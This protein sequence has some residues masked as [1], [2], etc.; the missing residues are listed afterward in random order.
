MQ[1]LNEKRAII[2]SKKKEINQKKVTCYYGRPI[3]VRGPVFPLDTRRKGAGF[4]IDLDLKETKA[5]VSK[6]YELRSIDQIEVFELK[7]PEKL[8]RYAMH[9]P[10]EEY[11]FSLD[12]SYVFRPTHFPIL[13]DYYSRDLID[14]KRV[15]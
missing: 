14:V 3:Y 2:K 7:M 4:F 6:L 12:H 5:V 15:R 1:L 10:F 9:D 13:N 8:F 11:N